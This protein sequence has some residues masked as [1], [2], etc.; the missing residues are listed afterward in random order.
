[1]EAA[2]RAELNAMRDFYRAVG[3]L[4]EVGNVVCG[5]MLQLPQSTMLN[6]AL[7]VGLERPATERQLDEIVTVF[8]ERGCVC[9]I[10][11]APEAEPSELPSWLEA[12]G[13]APGYAWMKFARTV[14][15]APRIDTDLRVEE[16]GDRHAD[17]FGR[18]LAA[19]Y[20]LPEEVVDTCAAVVGRPGWHC[21][22]AFAG[23]VPAG[24]AAL[25]AQDG[26]GWLGLAGTA[27]EL[28]RRGA[29]NALFAA[30]LARAAELGLELLA[31]ETG[32]RVADQPSSSY[33]NILRNGFEEAYLRPNWI[34]EAD[35]AS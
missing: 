15:P 34:R 11:V 10:A 28:Q 1:M 8:A 20:E 31:T 3:G 13:F 32:E 19:A 9:S 4:R 26:L 18:L 14:G 30:R 23:D 7:G 2:E 12:R 29:Q 35:H 22:L 21:F 24:A 27:P 16:A 6:R 25:H 33:R 5:F 17:R